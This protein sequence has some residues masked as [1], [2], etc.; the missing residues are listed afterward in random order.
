MYSLLA[1]WHFVGAKKMDSGMVEALRP[2]YN[3]LG[4]R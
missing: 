1:E 4:L 3:E 2:N